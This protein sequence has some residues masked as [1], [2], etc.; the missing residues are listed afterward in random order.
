[1]AG[2]TANCLHRPHHHET[3]NRID[4]LA[5]TWQQSAPYAVRTY[6]EVLV[7]AAGTYTPC[8]GESENETGRVFKRGRRS[9]SERAVQRFR[10]ISAVCPA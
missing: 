10:Q 8:G 9:V 3:S 6:S 2:E 7:V 4:D 5:H 1:M